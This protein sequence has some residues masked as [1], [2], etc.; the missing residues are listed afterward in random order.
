MKTCSDCTLWVPEHATSTRG[1]CHLNPLVV[2]TRRHD[3]CGQHRGKAGRPVKERGAI[4]I[5]PA[6]AEVILPPK[7]KKHESR[8]AETH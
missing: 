1:I 8:S 6:D 3:W 2:S 4:T 7:K 5:V